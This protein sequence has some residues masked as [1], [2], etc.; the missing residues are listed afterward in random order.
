MVRRTY[1]VSL[2]LTIG[3][4]AL[5]CVLVATH[6][7]PVTSVKVSG[8]LQRSYPVPAR[9]T[10]PPTTVTPTASQPRPTS[11]PSSVTS[12]HATPRPTR[13]QTSP[14]PAHWTQPRPPA[15]YVATAAELESAHLAVARAELNYRRTLA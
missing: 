11:R 8:N 6:S 12:T 15:R 10:V 9:T 1:V 2:I 7:Q 13:P 3:G 4:A 14:P 5:V